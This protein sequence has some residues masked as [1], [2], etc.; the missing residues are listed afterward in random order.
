MKFINAYPTLNLLIHIMDFVGLWFTYLQ[1]FE[2]SMRRY[3]KSYFPKLDSVWSI[4]WLG[5]LRY[6]QEMG[7]TYTSLR[8]IEAKPLRFSPI[9]P[10]VGSVKFIKAYPTLKQ[11]IIVF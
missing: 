4:P 10:T 1:L 2:K 5:L 8:S 7:I 9:H 3:M 6:I 11:S